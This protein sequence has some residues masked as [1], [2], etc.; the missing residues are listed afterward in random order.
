MKKVMIAAAF[1]L[2]F[3]LG[4]AATIARMAMNPRIVECVQGVENAETNAG[5]ASSD[6]QSGPDSQ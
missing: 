2:G 4:V 5:A 3:I 6:T 1:G